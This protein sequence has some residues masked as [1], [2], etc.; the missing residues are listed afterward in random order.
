MNQTDA[1][2]IYKTLA[3][4][5]G[6]MVIAATHKDWEQLIDLQTRCDDFFAYLQ[7]HDVAAF[8]SDEQV[9]EKRHLIEIVLTNQLQTQ[10]LVTP[11][12]SALAGQIHNKYNELLLVRA[13]GPSTEG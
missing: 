1:I 8:D 4:M 3:E 10:A 12:I 11:E 5:T 6:K 13:Y 2:L 9:Q 7:E